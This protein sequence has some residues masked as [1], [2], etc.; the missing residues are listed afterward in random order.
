MSKFKNAFIK[1]GRKFESEYRER[2]LSKVLEIA[3][4]DK[5]VQPKLTK[6]QTMVI[7]MPA[8]SFNSGGGSSILRIGAS[9]AKHDVQVYYVAYNSDDIKTS[10]SVAK[11][12]ISEFKGNYLTYNDAKHMNFDVVM[13]T[14]WT[15]VYYARLLHGYKIYFMQ[16]FEPLFYP[17][18]EEYILAKKT[19]DFGFHIISLGKWNAN[20]IAELCN[21]KNNV[22]TVDFP[23]EP[24]EYT[25]KERNFNDYETRK[26][27]KIAV[28]TKSSGRRIPIITQVLL[29]NTCDELNKYGYE[30]EVYF[31]GLLKGENVSV[32]KNLGLLT[33]KE[34]NELYQKVD[35]GMVASMTNISLVPY[36]MIAAGLPIIEFKDGSYES[37]LGD[38]TAILTSLDYHDLTNQLLEMLKDSSKIKKMQN[39]AINRISGLTWNNTCD[40]F[41]KILETSISK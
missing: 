25:F 34:L 22:D 17:M 39:S 36:E 23:Y 8:I 2:E 30:L 40:Q 11:K 12:A 4:F 6:I 35:F 19:Y 41:W 29:K 9:I 37:F 18:N 21:V 31:Y 13:A 10:E 27:F 24:K 1:I 33:K 14:N 26:K 28:Y 20:Q 7:V 38:D 5:I 16:D 15:S 3:Q 32:G